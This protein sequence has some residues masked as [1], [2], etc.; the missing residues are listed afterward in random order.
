MRGKGEGAVFRVPKDKRKPLKYWQGVVELPPG[1]NGERRRKFVR[2]KDKPALLSELSKLRAD[3]EKRGDLPTAT[4]TVEKW[5]TYWLDNIAAKKVRPNTLDG[6]RR[7]S[8]NHIIPAIGKVKL[9]KVT[10]T[11]VRRVH[12][13]VIEKGNSSTTALLA[14][15][16]MSI[17]FKA[18]VREGRIGRNPANLTDAP[19]K[20]ATTLH[21]LELPEA[22]Q[23]LGHLANDPQGAL[24]ATVLLTGARRGEVLGLER[25]RVGDVLDLSWQ[26]L[27]L[28]K[29]DTDGK[30]DVPADYEYRHVTGGLYLTRP[31]SSTSWRVI[32]LIDPL[33]SILEKHLASTPEN[34]WGLVFLRP[35][36][37]NNTHKTA[38]PR[39]YSPDLAGKDWR[40]VL[41]EAGID[42]DVRLHDGR[43]TTVDL[44][45]AAGVPD[46]LIQEIVG[47]STR[48]M[49]QAY[50]SLR[51]RERLTAA[52]EQFSTLFTAHAIDPPVPELSSR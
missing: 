1:P 44:L 33:K 18:A 32:P 12:D 37:E 47:H 43:H 48:T 3:L 6:Y 41:A 27:R 31:K 10:A 26:L 42:K 21:A 2:R 16:T 46:D 4:M 17:S 11:H 8:E 49:T 50:K 38:G 22:I 30:P 15:R 28:K 29:T 5:F 25:D 9:D 39:P 20:A 51:N 52:M 34:E 40:K 35:K 13:A 24:W 45:Y 19:R 23:L 7:T 36:G 14:H